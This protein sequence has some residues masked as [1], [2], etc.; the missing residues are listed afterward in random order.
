MHSLAELAQKSV[1]EFIR[2]GRAIQLSGPL[3]PDMRDKAGV[4]VCIK[5]D[6]QLRGCVGT[7][8]P[9]YENIAEETSRNAISAAVRD[10]RFPP[11][12]EEELGHLQYSVDVLSAPEKVK[13]LKELDPKEY[14]VIVTSGQRRGLLLPDLAGVDSVEE[15]LRITRMKAGILPDEDVEIFRFRVKR[16]K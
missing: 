15:Q 16:C 7:F 10:P 14:G 2:H 1:E 3:S 4:F 9:C 8:M 6:G 12:V 5:K 11:V 13:D